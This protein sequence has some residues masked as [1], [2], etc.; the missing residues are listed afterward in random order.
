M[1]EKLLIEAIVLQR[2]SLAEDF[3]NALEN[4]DTKIAV[5]R[6]DIIGKR[7]LHII[8]HSEDLNRERAVCVRVRYSSS[9]I[10]SR[11]CAKKI[12]AVLLPTFLMLYVLPRSHIS[13]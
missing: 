12:R 13:I 10:A 5:R 4:H 2:T 8:T 1:N 11:A 9:G 3:G 7:T 6:W